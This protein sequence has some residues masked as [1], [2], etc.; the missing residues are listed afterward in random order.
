MVLDF[1]ICIIPFIIWIALDC[2]INACVQKQGAIVFWCH[3]D[4]RDYCMNIA[5]IRRLQTDLFSFNMKCTLA[6]HQFNI[7]HRQ[8]VI[9]RVV[10]KICCE[11]HAY[12]SIYMANLPRSVL[13][14]N[15]Y[16]LCFSNV[17]Y[18]AIIRVI[19]VYRSLWWWILSDSI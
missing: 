6:N 17:L 5:T 13:V 12:K 3:R 4:E 9:I 16:V 8:K 10:F 1:W 18:I 2:A 19:C 11:Q 14:V 7:A 15:G